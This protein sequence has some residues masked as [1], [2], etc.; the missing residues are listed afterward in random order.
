MRDLPFSRTAGNRAFATPTNR[1]SSRGWETKL[2][3]G[4][5]GAGGPGLPAAVRQ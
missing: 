1:M 4:F 3:L 5:E 2:R